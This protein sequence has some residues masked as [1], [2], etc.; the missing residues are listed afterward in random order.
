MVRPI[1]CNSSN[2]SN[3]SSKSAYWV[4][5]PRSGMR[6]LSQVS[7]RMNPYIQ[8]PCCLHIKQLIQKRRLQVRRKSDELSSNIVHHTTIWRKSQLMRTP[9]VPSRQPW[10]SSFSLRLVTTGAISW[11]RAYNWIWSLWY[12]AQAAVCY[13]ILRLLPCWLQCWSIRFS[14]AFLPRRSNY[15]ISS[16]PRRFIV[17]EGRLSTIYHRARIVGDGLTRK[18]P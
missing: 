16:N 3:N 10:P 6:K 14:L 8:F 18:H 13:Y 15:Q 17:G 11:T 12:E 7:H 1:S 2:S 9:H 4:N 5:W